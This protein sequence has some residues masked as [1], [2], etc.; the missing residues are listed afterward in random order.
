MVGEDGG[1]PVELFGKHRARQ[2]VRPGRAAEA[3][4]QVG[5]VPDRRIMS[6]GGPQQEARLA[7]ASVAPPLQPVG[8]FARREGAAALVRAMVTDGFSASGRRTGPLSDN[9]VTATG[10][11]MRF[12]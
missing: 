12:T 8:E 9:S 11:V 4:Q 3:Q 5:A 2:H 7:C 10:Q 6:V 1:C